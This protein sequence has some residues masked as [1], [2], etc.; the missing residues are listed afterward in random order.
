MTDRFLFRV[1]FLAALGVG[2]LTSYRL[3]SAACGTAGGVNCEKVCHVQIYYTQ[4]LVGGTFPSYCS[5]TSNNHVP[6]GSDPDGV[7]TGGAASGVYPVVK[8]STKTHYYSCD[9]PNSPC[10]GPPAG[11][12]YFEVIQ[13]K[14]CVQLPDIDWYL[15]STPTPP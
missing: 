12:E 15:C 14:N 11:G 9:T 8:Q 10:S 3:G 7:C 13:A 4:G 6:K 2:V 5:G 1:L